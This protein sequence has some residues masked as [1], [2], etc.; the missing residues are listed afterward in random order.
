[1]R[2]ER[3][4]RKLEAGLDVP[5]LE[6]RSR[7]SSA[8][9]ESDAGPE[10][11]EESAQAEA[12]KHSWECWLARVRAAAK[13]Q[14]GVSNLPRVYKYT[15]RALPSTWVKYYCITWILLGTTKGNSVDVFVLH[16]HV[17]PRGRSVFRVYPR[18]SGFSASFCCFRWPSSASYR[19]VPLREPLDPLEDPLLDP[20]KT[21]EE[22]PVRGDKGQAGCVRRVAVPRRPEEVE[23]LV[24]EAGVEGS[25]VFS[26]TTSTPTAA[27]ASLSA[28]GVPSPSLILVC[29]CLVGCPTYPRHVPIAGEPVTLGA[30]FHVW[31][32]L[33]GGRNRS[34]T[35][36]TRAPSQQPGCCQLHC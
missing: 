11:T 1:M 19:C 3:V 21:A 27:A 31:V 22:Q 14:I 23:L 13:R 12:M 29:E 6:S 15:S 30:K 33:F 18:Q 35:P 5:H 25:E 20:K 10:A 36:P 32:A 7:G 26:P 28:I 17:D 8:R 4:W 2:P 16:A 9:G 34:R 24:G